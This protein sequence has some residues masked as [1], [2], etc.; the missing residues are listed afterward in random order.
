M[1]AI[2]TKRKL[3]LLREVIL[4]MSIDLLDFNLMDNEEVDEPDFGKIQLIETLTQ[5]T[6]ITDLKKLRNQIANV[7]LNIKKHSKNFAREDTEEEPVFGIN[8]ETL[9]K[10]LEQILET[11]SLERS[12]YYIKRLLKALTTNKSGKINDL[13]LNRWKEYED[14]VT[15]S[16][17]IMEKRDRSGAHNAGYWGNFIPQ[18]PQQLMKRYTK[19]G[20]WVLD[21]FIGSGTTLIECKRL[22]RNGIGID[23]SKDALNT[24]NEN[25]SK[26]ENKF[27]VRTEL[28]NAD[29]TT[30]DYKRMLD[31]AGL[32][33]V[34]LVIMHPPYWDIIKFS[35]NPNDLSNAINEKS[36]LD[37]IRAIGKKSY[38]I[39]DRGRYLAIV[40]GDKYSKGEWIPLGFESMNELRNIGFKLKSVVV[41]NFDVTKGKRNQEDLWRYRALAGGFYVFKHEYIFIFQR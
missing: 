37:S 17:W 40:I 27:G 39:L 41:K 29:S 19:K 18:I 11:Y 3:E 28:F 26:E 24:A 9:L 4:L 13:N 15:D 23:L 34:Q 16:L 14:I 10:D 7:S 2:I 33:S 31:L 32:K 6:E 35:E 1:I 38:E 21:T 8:N 36:F 25:L 30:L 20:E 22:G 12:Q 5:I